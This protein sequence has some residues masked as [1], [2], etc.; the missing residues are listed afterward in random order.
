MIDLIQKS[1]PINLTI[2][3]QNLYMVKHA[4][5]ELMLSEM[6]FI[7]RKFYT[8]MYCKANGYYELRL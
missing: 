1:L 8:Y 3:T 5:S 2:T 4:Y 7:P 6:I